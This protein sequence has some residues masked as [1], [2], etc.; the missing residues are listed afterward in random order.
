MAVLAEAISVIVR[1]DAVA[2]RLPGGT[3]AFLHA[4][5]NRTLCEDAHLYRIGFLSPDETA[6]FTDLLVTLGLVFLDENGVATDLAVADQQHGATTA[7]PWL[8]FG[9]VELADGPRRVSACWLRDAGGHP[10]NTAAALAAEPLAT[11]SGWR[12]EISL[13]R[14]FTFTPNASE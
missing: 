11:P 12:Y 10:E 1:K 6:D 13:S 14:Q 3:A 5:P 2:Q 9:Q 8:G 7:C 4:V